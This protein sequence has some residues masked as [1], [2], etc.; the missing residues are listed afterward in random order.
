[1]LPKFVA[2]SES[3][4]PGIDSPEANRIET[5]SSSLTRKLFHHMKIK[6]VES[7]LSK[8]VYTNLRQISI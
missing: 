1:M 8:V 6:G 3:L 4:L 7:N 2:S 5:V